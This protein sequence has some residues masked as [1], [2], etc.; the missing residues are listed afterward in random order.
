MPVKVLT[1]VLGLVL[2][3]ALA[4]SAASGPVYQAPQAYYL[5]LGDSIAYGFQPN[6]PKAAPPSAFDSGY[7][8]LFAA[9]LRKLS[10]TIQVVNYGC[11]GESTR[12]FAAGGCEGRGD[13]RRCTIPSRERNLT[14]RSPSCG[15][16]PVRSVR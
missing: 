13:V 9:R 11:P 14:R 12:T 1:G 7:V 8:D 2:L 6:K 10:P 5:A 4:A 15:P 16:I 3:T